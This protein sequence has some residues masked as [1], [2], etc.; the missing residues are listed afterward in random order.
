[1]LI[2]ENKELYGKIIQSLRSKFGEREGI[3]LSDLIYC[4]RKAYFRKTNQAPDASDEQLMMY[5]MGMAIQNWMF[6]EPEK[7]IELDGI[8]CSPDVASGI[9]VKSTRK[10]MGK[11]NVMEM[12]HWLKQ[13]KGYCKVMGKTEFDLV[14]FFVCGDYKPPF[15]KLGIPKTLTFTP[16]EIEENWNTMKER[17]IE[18]DKALKNNVA[19]PFGTEMSW[20]CEKC[21]IGPLY[22]KD[23]IASKGKR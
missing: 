18:L 11:F 12:E 15:P 6:P 2:T 10:S 23:Y 7:V 16:L 22:C 1:M 17:K 3:H 13:I 4:L 8:A 19:P 20:E 14:T 21:E 5:V 9:E